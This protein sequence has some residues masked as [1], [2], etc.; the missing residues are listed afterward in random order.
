M[1][2][3]D[4]SLHLPTS[5]ELPCSDDT[6]VDNEDQNFIP[7]FL[8]FLLEFIWQSRLDWFFGVDMGIY[9]TTGVSPLVPIVPDGFLSLGVERRKAKGSRKSYVLWEENNV[10]PIFVLEV[11]SLTYG[12]EYDSKMEIYAGLGVLYYVIYNPYYWRRDLHQPLEV[13]R[14]VNGEYQLQIGEPFW[15][16]EIGLGIGRAISRFGGLEREVLYWY[17]ERGSRYQTSEEVYQQAQQQAEA[18]RRE[19]EL[20]QQEVEA[21]RRERELAQQEAAKLAEL[22]KRYRERFGELSEND[23]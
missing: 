23:E 6:P 4:F 22:L 20:A 1:V 17:D 8:L 15:M 11:V 9:H 13:Y 19:R 7:N 10:P 21:E 3:S 5:D 14:L 2:Q 12:G 16:S 18:E